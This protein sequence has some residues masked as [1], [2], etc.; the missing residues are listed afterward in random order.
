MQTTNKLNASLLKAQWR[1]AWQQLYFKKRLLAWMIAITIVLSIFPIFLQHIEKRNG[2]EFSDVV[3]NYFTPHDV[4]IPIFFIIWSTTV[5]TIRKAIRQPELFLTLA[6][7]FLVL[8]VARLI[9]ITLVPLN[10]PHGLIPLK[11]PITGIFYGEHFI[12]KDLFFSG[13]TANQFLL[14]LCLEKTR[15]KL[16]LLVATLL[17]AVLVL[18]QHVHYTCDVLAAPLFTYGCYALGKKLALREVQ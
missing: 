4:S 17:V 10:P 1:N 15:D 7:G 9:T 11:D 12:T 8:C 5:F 18:V 2:Y 6:Y 3:L 14:F 13:H 16:L